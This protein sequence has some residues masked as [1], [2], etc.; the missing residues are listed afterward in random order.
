MKLNLIEEKHNENN[1]EN[2]T[3]KD[4][5]INDKNDF[6]LNDEN[7]KIEDQK[8]AKNEDDDFDDFKKDW[9]IYEN[10]EALSVNL[11][12]EGEKDDKKENNIINEKN[13]NNDLFNDYE[14]I[15]NYN[16]KDENIATSKKV[17]V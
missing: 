7:L 3:E 17:E 2:K 5:E 8:I 14:I 9:V 11:N 4:L 1:I 16:E 15:E 6:E 13:D 10:E 12:E